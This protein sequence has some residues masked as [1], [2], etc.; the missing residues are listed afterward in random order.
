LGALLL[1]LFCVS[2]SIYSFIILGVINKC[3]QAGNK[4]DGGLQEC[5]GRNLAPTDK[6]I[7]H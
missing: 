7:F 4:Y 5:K 6:L 2:V 3:S 1:R